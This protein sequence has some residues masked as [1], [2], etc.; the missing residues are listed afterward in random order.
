MRKLLR[1]ALAALV[2]TAGAAVAM[3]AASAQIDVYATPGYHT[4]NGRQ[5]RT[6]CEPYSITYRCRTEIKATV[7]N[8][9]GGRFVQKTGW[10]FN[11]LTYLASPRANWAANPLGRTGA[12]TASD[13]RQWRW[14][15]WPRSATR[16]LR[17]PRAAPPPSA[18]ARPG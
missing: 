16:W 12:W 5:W 1:V 8:H 18:A 7:V 9:V 3:P 4:I 13:S 11:N 2:A 15:R 6:A 10:A 17:L 14:S